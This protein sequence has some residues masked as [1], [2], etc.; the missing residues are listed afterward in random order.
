VIFHDDDEKGIERLCLYEPLFSFETESKDANFN[1]FNLD[2]TA[3]HLSSFFVLDQAGQIQCY[4]YLE[5]CLVPKK[6]FSIL[7]LIGTHNYQFQEQF[8]DL[9]KIS[10]FKINF[11]YSVIL[12]TYDQTFYIIDLS[13]PFMY[14]KVPKKWQKIEDAIVINQS[15]N[16]KK[17]FC[18]R[19][20]FI[21]GYEAGGK[22]FIIKI[23]LK[24]KDDQEV[25]FI[26][27]AVGR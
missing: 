14:R 23:A 18:D 7:D 26:Q 2:L 19:S 13:D 21:V 17:G 3:V 8:P 12:L 1:I 27:K 25:E 16:F 20:Y 15:R 6:S 24:P 10:F 5:R 9:S 11:N 4:N 22:Y